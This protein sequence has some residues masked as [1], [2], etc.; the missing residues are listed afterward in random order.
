MYELDTNIFLEV[1]L[2]QE[3]TEICSKL[4]T[5]I[6]TGEITAMLLDFSVDGIVIILE[7]YHK[8]P[9]E[10]RRFLLSLL[11]Y[12]GL[13]IYPARMTD[14]IRATMKMTRYKLDFDD[15][16]VLQ[17]AIS[18]GCTALI[19]LDRDFSKVKEFTCLTPTEVL[20]K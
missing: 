16:L 8:T 11:G 13:R 19:S 1:L 3:H 4:L 18:N 14:K 17:C 10:I 5:K 9:E 6:R 7:R 2:Q 15:S 12:S 20:E